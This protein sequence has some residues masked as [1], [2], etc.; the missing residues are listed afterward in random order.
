M[1]W[2]IMWMALGVVSGIA[3][4][5]LLSVQLGTF[6]VLTVVFVLLFVAFKNRGATEP[7]SALADCGAG[8][9]QNPETN[10][11][12]LVL[13]VSTSQQ[14]CDA[15]QYRNPETNRCKKVALAGKNMPNVKDVESKMKINRTS[16]WFAGVAV[17]ATLNYNIYEWRHDIIQRLRRLAYRKI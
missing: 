10:R 3:L 11:C 12:R 13:S 16:W 8:K 1:S 5:V 2:L 7:N 17:S 4:A 6:Q 9:E 15:N 14:T